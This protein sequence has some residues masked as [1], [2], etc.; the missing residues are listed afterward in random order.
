M[1][2]L[3]EAAHV[4]CG[5]RRSAVTGNRH[6]EQ[7]QGAPSARVIPKTL[8]ASAE[9]WRRSHPCRR[10]SA[11]GSSMTRFDGIVVASSEATRRSRGRRRSPPIL[12]IASRATTAALPSQPATLQLR[13]S[14]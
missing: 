14:P 12:W 4:L 2:R 1:S 11:P 5:R 8:G 13:P 3:D 6:G 10:A 7:P 9:P